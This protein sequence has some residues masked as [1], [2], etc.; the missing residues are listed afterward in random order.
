M[1]NNYEKLLKALL[2]KERL[3][4]KVKTRRKNKLTTLIARAAL[5]KVIDNI[6]NIIINIQN[7]RNHKGGRRT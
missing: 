4:D 1:L 3:E 5:H 6:D 7:G 2:E